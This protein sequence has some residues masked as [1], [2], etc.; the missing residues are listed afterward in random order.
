MLGHLIGRYRKCA[1]ESP[2]GLTFALVGILLEGTQSEG[3]E[4]SSVHTL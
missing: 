4:Y 3:R 1:I 2:D